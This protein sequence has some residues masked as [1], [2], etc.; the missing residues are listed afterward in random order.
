MNLTLQDIGL[1]K[2]DKTE[3]ATIFQYLFA[4][5]AK[6]V[7]KLSPAAYVKECWEV[8]KSQYP[9]PSANINGKIFEFI[10]CTLLYGKGIL[11]LYVNAKVAF[12]P[13]VIYDIMIYCKEHGPI[14][15]SAKTSLRERYKQADLEAVAL[16]YVNRRSRYYLLTLDER[17]SSILKRKIKDGQL[18]GIDRVILA[19]ESTDLDTLLL[20]LQSLT[21]GEAPSI[22]IIQAQNVVRK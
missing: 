10:L 11:P 20:E 14:A 21:L 5:W 9:T 16:K 2:S 17:E 22:P 13:N 7:Q 19:S 15:L 1:A 6:R 18:L 4:D 3:A 12:V 8:Y